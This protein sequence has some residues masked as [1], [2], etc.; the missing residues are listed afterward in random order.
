MPRWYKF[1]FRTF[2]RNSK[3]IEYHL[4]TP[5]G[6]KNEYIEKSLASK[7]PSPDEINKRID[8]MDEYDDNPWVYN[9]DED[10]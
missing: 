6:R 10:K 1:M 3:Y 9:E 7:F 4:K 5:L 8:S 2:F